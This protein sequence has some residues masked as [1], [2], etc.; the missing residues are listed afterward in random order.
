MH[1]FPCILC[2][3]LQVLFFFTKVWAKRSIFESRPTQSYFSSPLHRYSFWVPFRGKECVE[4]YSTPPYVFITQCLSKLV[5]ETTSGMLLSKSA[6]CIEKVC[7]EP[8]TPLENTV[9]LPSGNTQKSSEVGAA[10][11]SLCNPAGNQTA[12]TTAWHSW[13]VTTV[14]YNINSMYVLQN[15]VITCLYEVSHCFKAVKF[16]AFQ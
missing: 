9:G 6:G 8:K 10:R 5:A 15:I 7:V 11:K 12:Q 1:Y 13:D 2:M 3:D 16:N 4:L 14:Y